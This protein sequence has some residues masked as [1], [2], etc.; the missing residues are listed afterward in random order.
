MPSQ[1]AFPQAREYA[2]PCPCPGPCLSYTRL[3]STGSG[4]GSGRDPG[5]LRFRRGYAG[6]ALEVWELVGCGWLLGYIVSSGVL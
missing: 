6:G 2:L 3:C 5:R 1:R 4:S